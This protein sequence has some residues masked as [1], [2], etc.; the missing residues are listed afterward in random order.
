[1]IRNRISLL[2]VIFFIAAFFFLALP[3]KGYSGVPLGCCLSPPNGTTHC[4]GCDGLDCATNFSQCQS[5]NSFTGLSYC[6]DDGGGAECVSASIL[7]GCC[8]DSEGACLDQGLNITECAIDNE[9]LAWYP[10][11]S[12]LEVPE[13]QNGQI[14][15]TI[16]TLSEWALIAVAGILGI[17]GYLVIRRRRLTV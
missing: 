9:G 14:T 17:V 6:A 3:E 16:P 12:C 11:T 10:E 13:C 15:S 4:I 1:M 8:V 5:P 7:T 2:L